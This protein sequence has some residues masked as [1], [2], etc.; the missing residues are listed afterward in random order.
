MSPYSFDGGNGLHIA[1]RHRTKC[2]CIFH[3]SSGDPFGAYLTCRY[4]CPS[5]LLVVDV[6]PRE[7]FSQF[8][9]QSPSHPRVNVSLFFKGLRLPRRGH[10]PTAAARFMIAP[11]PPDRLIV[12]RNPRR[13][14]A[15]IRNTIGIAGRAPPPLRSSTPF[16][17][18]RFSHSPLFL[19][20]SPA[21]FV[22]RIPRNAERIDR[23]NVARLYL[24]TI[25]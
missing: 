12:E 13:D 10:E 14:L 18:R 19:R 21:A 23:G 4:L 16:F 17:P 8:P 2:L 3:K 11:D 22:S 5:S 7:I 24:S 15:S 6:C 20:I 25:T 1:W 9:R